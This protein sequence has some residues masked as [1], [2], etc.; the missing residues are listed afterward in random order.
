MGSIC[1][2]FLVKFLPMLFVWQ[3]YIKLLSIHILQNA[4]LSSFITSNNITFTCSPYSD[5]FP[6]IKLSKLQQ[7]L[8]FRLSVHY[9]QLSLET[10]MSGLFFHHP[11]KSYALMSCASSNWFLTED[12]RAL[13]LLLTLKSCRVF[14]NHSESKNTLALNGR[15]N[16]HIRVKQ[17]VCNRMK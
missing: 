10:I 2:I 7:L 8:V 3:I 13:V 11:S 9:I 16:K 14:W 5:S 6:A 4:S 15:Q 1:G 17:I 12:T